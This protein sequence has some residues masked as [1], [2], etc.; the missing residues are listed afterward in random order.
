MISLVDK[1]ENKND[2]DKLNID[3]ILNDDSATTEFS[4]IKKDPTQTD[5]IN[6]TNNVANS[7]KI[8]KKEVTPINS[9]QNSVGEKFNISFDK[10]VYQ[11]KDFTVKKAKKKRYF[12][13]TFKVFKALIIITVAGVL[14]YGALFSIAEVMGE[15]RESGAVI[16]EIEKGDTVYDVA[17]KLKEKD[18]IRSELLFRT[19]V[20]LLRID[21]NL[22]YGVHKIDGGMA[23]GEII[24]ELQKH[25]KSTE[26]VKVTFP[27]GFTLLKIASRL[28][29]NEVCSADDFLEA[30]NSTD[31]GFDF[32]AEVS[33]NELKYFKKEGFAFPDTYTF[34]KG[35]D[36]YNVA[37]KL[38]KNFEKK[39]TPEMYARMNELK[40]PLEEM[41]IIAS[42]VQSEAGETEEM[43][44]VASVYLNR[45]N[46]EG[47]YPN[48][49]ADPTRK[50]AREIKAVM[51]TANQEILSAYN[52]YE[53]EG[54][55]P[56]AIANPGMDAIMATLYP[57]ETPYYYFC[58]NLNTRK[59]FYAETLAE[60]EQN[61]F[62]AGL[63]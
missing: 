10:D 57:D 47:V 49:Q 28:E 1:P 19:Y 59:F 20:K 48:L 13:S 14:A 53:G 15:S 17:F 3:S 35:E 36:P 5:S 12:S 26:S 52:T 4:A 62:R 6:D 41:I 21:P 58:T 60:H 45:L 37:N 54:L 55:P 34:E 30:F 51:D 44:K 63:V 39:I 50:Y 38:A 25:T 29:A 32:E 11:V 23:Y 7:I 18:V 56:G 61:L 2:L 16:F 31:F 46:N 42:I 40:M 27:E 24:Y 43:K 9:E 8:T 33:D 22:Q